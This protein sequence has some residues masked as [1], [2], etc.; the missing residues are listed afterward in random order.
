MNLKLKTTSP[1]HSRD[2][3]KCPCGKN[4]NPALLNTRMTKSLMTFLTLAFFAIGFFA[5]TSNASADYYTQGI[6]ES[7]NMLSGATVTAINGFQI[8]QS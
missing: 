5:F 8:V 6:L 4:G 7:K 2:Q 3:R 1:C